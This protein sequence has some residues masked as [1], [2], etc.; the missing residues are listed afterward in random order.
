MNLLSSKVTVEL[1]SVYKD[2]EEVKKTVSPYSRITVYRLKAY[3]DVITTTTRVKKE[4]T[5]VLCFSYFLPKL[6]FIPVPKISTS[7]T[8]SPNFYNVRFILFS[9]YYKEMKFK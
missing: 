2:S 3:V 8:F 4:P 9:N 5:K 1:L 6:K 7:F